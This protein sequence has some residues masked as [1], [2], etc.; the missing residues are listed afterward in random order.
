MTFFSVKLT[1]AL[2]AASLSVSA[3]AT[4]K[5][6]ASNDWLTQQI[7]KHP[8]IVAAKE[9]MNAVFSQAQ[10]SKKA[11]Y[12][13]ELTSGY[14]REGDAN[15]FEIGISQKIDWWDK[16]ETREQ[17]F[18]FNLTQVS[19]SFTFLQ[20]EKMAQ[21]LQALITFKAA[22]EQAEIAREQEQ[23]LST[24]LEIVEQRQQTGDLGQVDAELTYLSLSQILNNTA[25]AQVK[26]KQTAAQVKE[27][28]PDWTADRNV[29][30]T[31]GMQINNN[32]ASSLMQQEWLEKHPLVL[33]AK[34][35]W[36][37]S[38]AQAQLAQLETKAEPTFGVRAGKTDQDTL[39]GLDFSMPLNIRNDFSEVAR[40]ANQFANAA[41]SSYRSVLRK[42]KFAIQAS[43]DTLIAYQNNYQ[44]WVKL[45]QGRGKRSE[46]L[47][48]KQWQSGDMSTTEYLLALQQRAEGLNAGIELKSQYRLSQIDWLLQVGQVNQA[49]KQLSR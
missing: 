21:A 32:D 42:Q 44:R 34:A 30:P 33:A 8:D 39:I 11:L 38:K 3:F 13:P 25:Q 31:Q 48:T 41:E 29:L 17:Q 27:L 28:L 6:N 19:K 9:T 22:R 1:A 2:I 16:R 24:L 26:L 40:A 46:D 14:E 18:N 4:P 10:G 12:N 36:Q 37:S 23:Q 43:N 35:Q 45:M 47:L 20:Q 7:N 15:N 5:E 49:I